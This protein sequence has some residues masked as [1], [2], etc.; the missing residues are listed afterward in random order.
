[1]ADHTIEA[2]FKVKASAI[3]G[4]QAADL[5]A[6]CIER[7][8]HAACAGS[9]GLDAQF[10]KDMATSVYDMMLAFSEFMADLRKHGL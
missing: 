6:L 8:A 2:H 4:Q 5:R 9:P 3:A 10:A 7:M 1:M